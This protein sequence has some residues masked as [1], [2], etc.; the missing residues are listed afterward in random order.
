M[1]ST[2]TVTATTALELS[3]E[4]KKIIEKAIKEK[5]SVTEVTVENTIDPT[6][7]G[8]IK[9]SVNGTEYDSTVTGKL[10]QVRSHLMSQF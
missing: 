10:N 6:C 9:L 5:Y 4:Q 3:A 8:G 2:L 1:H 7:I